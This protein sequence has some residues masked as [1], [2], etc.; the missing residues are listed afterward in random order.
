MS[1]Q[2][3]SKDELQT[4]QRKNIKEIEKQKAMEVLTKI[5]VETIALTLPSEQQEELKALFDDWSG[6]SVEYKV[7]KRVVYENVLYKVIIKHTSQPDWTPDVAHSLFAKVLTSLDGTPKEWV[8]PDS[9]NPY[10]K[11]DKVLYQ[12]KTYESTIDNN[13]WSPTAYPQGWKDVM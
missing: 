3:K 5:Q 12:G 13:V 4:E 7:D 9:T 1:I 11:G 10:M 2:W 6:A 8:Q